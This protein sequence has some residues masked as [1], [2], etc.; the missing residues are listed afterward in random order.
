MRDG[1]IPRQAPLAGRP[2]RLL[3]RRSYDWTDRYPLVAK[4]V[5]ALQANSVTIDGEAVCC[6][7]NG[8]SVFEELHSRQG[9]DRV[10]R[11]V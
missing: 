7:E 9:D 11:A 2:V 5:A 1:D 10:I 6:D 3:T 8:V 4:A